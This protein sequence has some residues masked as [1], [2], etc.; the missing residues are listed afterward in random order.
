MFDISNDICV[1]FLLNWFGLY[2]NNTLPDA[3]KSFSLTYLLNAKA[4]LPTTT[5]LSSKLFFGIKS[6]KYI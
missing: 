2:V 5:I 6:L 1:D 4:L 3:L